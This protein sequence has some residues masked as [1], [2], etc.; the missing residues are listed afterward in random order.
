MLRAIWIFNDSLEEF[1][2]HLWQEWS[3]PTASARSVVLLRRGMQVICPCLPHQPASHSQTTM[4]LRPCPSEP[5]SLLLW[6]VNLVRVFNKAGAEECSEGSSWACAVQRHP[7]APLLRLPGMRNDLSRAQLFLGQFPLAT[8]D[9]QLP[10]R[11]TNSGTSLEWSG[12]SHSEAFNDS[13]RLRRC[14]VS[15]WLFIS[16]PALS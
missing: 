6:P 4:I 10:A 2:H 11:N 9:F 7:A 8:S 13:V 16:P 5:P 15:K 14:K 12:E 3:A 1:N